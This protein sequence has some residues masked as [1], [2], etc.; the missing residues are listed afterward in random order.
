MSSGSVNFNSASF[1]AWP[2]GSAQT[3]FTP[4]PPGPASSNSSPGAAGRLVKQTPVPSAPQELTVGL[5]TE[6]ASSVGR[7]VD[8]IGNLI[9]PSTRRA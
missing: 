9:G 1:G 7:L 4:S 6:M 2:I 5:S 8:L 3:T